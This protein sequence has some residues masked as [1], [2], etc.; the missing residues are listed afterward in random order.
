M[1][2]FNQ[3]DSKVEIVESLFVI[4]CVKITVTSNWKQYS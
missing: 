4:L 1:G 3:L 2:N